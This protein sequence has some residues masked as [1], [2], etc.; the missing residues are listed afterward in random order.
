[1]NI[2]FE[3]VFIIS[4]TQ[5]YV[6]NVVLNPQI[7]KYKNLRLEEDHRNGVYVELLHPLRV[8][9]FGQVFGYALKLTF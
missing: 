1:M 8:E 2:T 6:W 7:G 9:R 5:D 4:L 3:C